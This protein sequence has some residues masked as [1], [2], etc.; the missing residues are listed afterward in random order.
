MGFMAESGVGELIKGGWEDYIGQG[1]G[2]QFPENINLVQ[3]FQE[4][5]VPTCHERSPTP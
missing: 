4:V 1:E 2:V 5:Q 3:D